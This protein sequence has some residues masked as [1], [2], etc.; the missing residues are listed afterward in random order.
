MNGSALSPTDAVGIFIEGEA[1]GGWEAS[2]Y[3]NEGVSNRRLGIPE[4]SQYCEF[5]VLTA[6]LKVILGPYYLYIEATNTSNLKKNEPTL[7]KA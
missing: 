4:L 5:E 3:E 6:V 1:R 2:K 7:E